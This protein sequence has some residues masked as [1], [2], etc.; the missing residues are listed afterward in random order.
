MQVHAYAGISY[1]GSTE[2]FFVTGTTGA[3][4]KY[5]DSKGSIRRGVAAEEY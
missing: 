3:K 1:K 2:L 5:K 4:S